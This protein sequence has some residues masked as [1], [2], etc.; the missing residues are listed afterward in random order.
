VKGRGP[1]IRKARGGKLLTVRRAVLAK[2]H[3][4][5]WGELFEKADVVSE[6]SVKTEP[7]GRTWYGTTSVIL[8][9]DEERE[10]HAKVAAQDLHVRLRAVRAAC[11][12]ASLRAPA[13]LGGVSCEIHV[14]E[15]AR[16]VR[17]DVEVQAPLIE[18]ATGAKPVD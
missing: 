18:G 12:E 15:D 14:T 2:T 9:L 10:A 16:G 5:G 11:R 6:G 17:I 1:G 13:P 3:V 7:E 8:L 4:R